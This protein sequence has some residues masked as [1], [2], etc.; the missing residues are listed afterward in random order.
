MFDEV[1]ELIPIKPRRWQKSRAVVC[2]HALQGGGPASTRRAIQLRSQAVTFI[3]GNRIGNGQP[4]RAQKFAD[5]L[6]P[7]DYHDRAFDAWQQR[8]RD[9]EF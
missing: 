8:C 2:R 9:D 3:R 7:S 5:T 6:T 1:F 4:H